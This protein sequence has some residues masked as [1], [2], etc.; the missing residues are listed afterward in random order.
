VLAV[1]LLFAAVHLVAIGWCMA[2]TL[3]PTRLFGETGY[4]I[5]ARAL[6]ILVYPAAWFVEICPDNDTYGY[7]AFIGSSVIWGAALTSAF[8]YLRK[9]RRAPR[10]A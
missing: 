9:R 1:V 8:L 6:D 5:H 7:T 3:T 2:M 10:V 4:R